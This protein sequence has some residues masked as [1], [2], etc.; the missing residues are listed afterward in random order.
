MVEVLFK[1]PQ[2]QTLVLRKDCIE[3]IYHQQKSLEGDI[4]SILVLHYQIWVRQPHSTLIIELILHR[5]N[6][7][8]FIE[9]LPMM[10]KQ[11]NRAVCGKDAHFTQYSVGVLQA[12]FVWLFNVE[13]VVYHRNCAKLIAI[14][15][16]LNGDH[17]SLAHTEHP[18]LYF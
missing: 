13:H 6:L 15:V 12:Q 17:F 14:K 7:K 9:Q 5:E 16:C 4:L 10:Y 11:F 1:V 3:Q 18:C 8:N 2:K